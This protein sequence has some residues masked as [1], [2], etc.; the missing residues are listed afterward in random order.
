DS[1]GY[2][3]DRADIVDRSGALV[4]TSLPTASLYADP[5]DIIDP[6]EAATKLQTVLPEIKPEDLEPRLAAEGKSFVWIRRNLTPR[7]QYEVN[8]LGIPGF[9]FQREDKRIYPHGA[10]MAHVVG[11]TDI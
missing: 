5:R 4:A 11:F 3:A 7:Q 6:H 2:A 10:L 9:Y 1:A 8:R